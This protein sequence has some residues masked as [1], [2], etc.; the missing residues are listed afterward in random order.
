MIRSC[1]SLYELNLV[2]P[3]KFKLADEV[4]S[5]FFT[6]FW[7]SSTIKALIGM[8]H[9]NEFQSNGLS[10]VLFLFWGEGEA[11]KNVQDRIRLESRDADW[12]KPPHEMES[13]EPTLSRDS[14]NRFNS[15]CNN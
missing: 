4:P 14:A 5:F 7:P 10:R 13:L 8:R 12:M 11:L 15:F 6:E 2:H 1:R 9:R 3:Y